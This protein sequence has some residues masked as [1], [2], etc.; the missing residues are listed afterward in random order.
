MANGLAMR[1][2][3][4]FDAHRLYPGRR[5]VL[6]G[7]EVP[8]PKG[9]EGHSDADVAAHALMDALLGAA[10]LGDIGALFPDTDSEYKGA[11]SM[12]LLE[13][14]AEVLREKGYQTGNADITII[15]ERPKL[16]GYAAQMRENVAAALGTDGSNI[17]V[18]A[19]STEGMSFEGEGRGISAHAVVIITRLS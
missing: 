7:V 12:K 18:K 3:H 2:G 13:R 17:S 4:G 16:S 6:F 19:T 11:D 1:I 14:V 9:L 8:F 15:A 5:L 10:G